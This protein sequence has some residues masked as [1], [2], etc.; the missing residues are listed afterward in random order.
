MNPAYYFLYGLY[1]DA[2]CT[3]KLNCFSKQ[4]LAKHHGF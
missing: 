3:S 1:S 4:Y 2:F